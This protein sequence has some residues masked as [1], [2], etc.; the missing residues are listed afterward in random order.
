MKKLE[1]FIFVIFVQINMYNFY[2]QIP[3]FAQIDY[4]KDAIVRNRFNTKIC[5]KICAGTILYLCLPSSY[6]YITI[7]GIQL[8]WTRL[9]PDWN[10]WGA[11]WHSHKVY[12]IHLRNQHRCIA[13]FGMMIIALGQRLAECPPGGVCP[14]INTSLFPPAR[15]FSEKTTPRITSGSY[16]AIL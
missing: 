1:F 10:N 8:Q 7:I 3:C 13:D 16:S 5:Q 12:Y 6:I 2:G 14:H 15:P 4:S 11:V 9:A